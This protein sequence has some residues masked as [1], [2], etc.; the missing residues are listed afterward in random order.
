MKSAAKPLSD[1][2]KVLLW[3]GVLAVLAIVSVV[4]TAGCAVVPRAVESS[5]ASFDGNAQNS[6]VVMSTAAGFVV[7]DR[8]RARYNAMIVTYGADFRPPLAIDAGVSPIGEDRWLITK[9]A[10]VDFLTMNA[11]RKAGLKPK[12]P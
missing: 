5:E 2:A 3:A 9:Q 11:W 1:R 7:T 6:G 12:A 8:F 10:M 4:A